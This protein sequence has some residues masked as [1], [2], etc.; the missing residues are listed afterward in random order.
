MKIKFAG[1]ESHIPWREQIDLLEVDAETDE[2]GWDDFLEA[3]EEGGFGGGGGVT[4]VNTP[5][6]NF[7]RHGE[8]PV[9]V[10][11]A[12]NWDTNFADAQAHA[13]SVMAKI[14]NAR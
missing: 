3:M 12:R 11:A 7:R 5:M 1:R 2:C 10:A 9:K 8:A 13:R 14:G 6:P 4:R